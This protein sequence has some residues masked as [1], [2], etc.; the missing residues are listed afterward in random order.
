MHVHDV[1][2]GSIFAILVVLPTGM[3]LSG[4]LTWSLFG[5]IS[6]AF[7]FL[8]LFLVGV[9]TENFR[10][11]RNRTQLVRAA[12]EGSNYIARLQD[13]ARES[14]VDLSTPPPES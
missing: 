9:V 10:Q 11:R 1:R 7:V 8:A 5:N 13:A 4:V 6:G 12:E 2:P 3:A 14:G